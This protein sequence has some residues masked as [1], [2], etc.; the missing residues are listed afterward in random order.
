[1]CINVLWL[2]G[3]CLYVCSHIHIFIFTQFL[4]CALNTLTGNVAARKADGVLQ[5]QM[6][7]LTSWPCIQWGGSAQFFLLHKE[8][9]ESRRN[10][11]AQTKQNGTN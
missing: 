5:G 8:D 7:I 11:L 9:N 4:G 1:M 3:C 2:G 6:Q 10:S